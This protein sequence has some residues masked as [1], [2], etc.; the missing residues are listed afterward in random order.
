MRHGEAD[1]VGRG[2]LF[3]VFGLRISG[4]MFQVIGF[5]YRLGFEVTVV[6]QRI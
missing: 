1:K 6:G 5:S 2:N 3:L 4:Y